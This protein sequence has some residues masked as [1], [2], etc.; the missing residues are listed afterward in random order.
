MARNAVKVKK[1]IF[2][3][4]WFW[5]IVVLV[6]VG[7]FVPKKDSDN[8]VSPV[9]N[10]ATPTEATTESTETE[11]EKPN[12]EPKDEPK[13]NKLTLGS[14]F[15]F[16]NLQLTIGDTIGWDVV[17]NQYSDNN[18]AEVVT[19][20]VTVKNIGDE[21]NSLNMFFYKFFGSKGTTLDTVGSYFDDD[22]D[23]LGDLRPDAEINGNF[24][25]MYDGDGTYYIEFDNFSDKIEVEIPVQK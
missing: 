3:R 14:T 1:P 10:N 11:S 24:H 7:L 9:L 4:W 12:D 22:A 16:D 20:P 5:V 2:K 13:D 15:E 17:A 21:T 8:E 18:G 25:M 19:I 6:L 23:S